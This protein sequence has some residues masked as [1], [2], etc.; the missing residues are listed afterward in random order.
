MNPDI[1]K[2]RSRFQSVVGK[3]TCRSVVSASNTKIVVCVPQVDQEP[4]A[5]HLLLQW[6]SVVD[7]IA[8]AGITNLE[9][10]TEAHGC[11]VTMYTSMSLFLMTS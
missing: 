6:T 8:S 9:L 3:E 11:P 5:D 4:A 10:S 1:V 2:E 7:L